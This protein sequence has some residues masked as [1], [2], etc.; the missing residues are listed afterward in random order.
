MR[1]V[2]H[3]VSHSHVSITVFSG[4]HTMRCYHLA[5]SLPGHA[6]G[7]FQSAL[8]VW[9]STTLAMGIVVSGRIDFVRVP[10]VLPKPLSAIGVAPVSDNDLDCFSSAVRR[11]VATPSARAVAVLAPHNACWGHALLWSIWER[12]GGHA[13]LVNSVSPENWSAPGPWHVCTVMRGWYGRERYS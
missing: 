10:C 13:Y 1:P 7:L 2:A 9:E 11:V 12:S 8:Q 6:E 4:Y 5:L 3:P